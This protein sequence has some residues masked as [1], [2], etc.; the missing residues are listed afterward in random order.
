MFLI[1][2]GPPG[3][4]KGTQAELLCKNHNFFHFSTGNI[5]RDE[6][7]NKTLIGKKI[8]EIINEGKLVSDS[9]II[10]IVDNVITKE[11]P[12]NKGILLDGFPRNLSQALALNSLLKKKKYSINCVIHIVIDNSEIVKRIKKRK[13]IEGRQDDNINILKS[14]LDVYL[15]ETKPLMNHY[16]KEKKIFDVNGMQTIDNVNKDI[17]KIILNI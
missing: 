5:L 8:K 12:L 15:K 13:G 7:N 10:K 9:I 11:L 16:K 2:L 17:N 4:G 14:R 3:A 6:I 1:L